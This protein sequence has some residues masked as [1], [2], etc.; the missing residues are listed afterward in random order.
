MD[1][2]LRKTEPEVLDFGEL[3]CPK[4]T[5]ELWA[6]LPSDLETTPRDNLPLGKSRDML[7]L[8][9][10][11][12]HRDAGC[13]RIQVFRDGKRM[14]YL[15]LGVQGGGFL[16]PVTGLPVKPPSQWEQRNT[17][18][19]RT[20]AGHFRQFWHFR[21]LGKLLGTP[22]ADF[23]LCV[24]GLRLCQDGTCDRAALAAATT[25][26]P[27][28]GLGGG[29]DAICDHAGIL[30][31]LNVA[32]WKEVDRDANAVLCPLDGPVRPIVGEY[33][34]PA[35]A[36]E[37]LCGQQIVFALCPHC[38]GNFETVLGMMN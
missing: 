20:I 11:L 21:S 23:T 27:G 12:T 2:K 30:K 36:W 26:W 37:D 14:H 6:R 34:T 29:D 38:L 22:A 25:R 31:L 4:V 32:A 7:F 8:A 24:D 28:W 17:V 9:R 13:N 1:R 3:L 33:S 18:K 16:H 5:A 35:W 15:L 10:L 19:L